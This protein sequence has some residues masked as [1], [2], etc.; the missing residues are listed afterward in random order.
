MTHNVDATQ[1]LIVEKSYDRVAT[2]LRDRVPGV[3]VVC[4]R[5][6]RNFTRDAKAV[7][8]A[9]V[10]P[11]AAWIGADV[12]SGG[13]LADY[14]EV[15]LGFES[16]QWV[17]SANAG[18]DA[19]LYQALARRGVRLTK[20]GAQSIPIAEY[21]LAYA[22]ERFQDLDVRRAAQ[23]EAAWKPHRFRELWHA[24]WLI[25]GYGHIGRG[26]ARRAKAFDSR[27]IAIRASG[28]SHEYADEVATLASL[29]ELLPRAN[30]VVLACPATDETRGLAN[31]SFFERLGPDT[32]FINVARGSL[33]DEAALLGGL[34]RERPSHAVLDVFQTEPLPASSP[35]WNHPRVTV[36]A[37]TSNAGSGT[38]IRG[39][40]LFLSNLER[41]VAGQALIDE[42][43]R[44]SLI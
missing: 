41:F 33:V 29:R 42:V 10:A 3:D 21:V 40:E 11:A 26:V 8:C 24:T 15:L 16:L 23:A 13:H 30:V 27:V 18:L 28:A 14:G 7:D 20:S 36:T 34:A 25:I 37:H 17:Q 4:W 1:V 38:R 32:L 39:D 9:E 43:D 2:G 5:P 35:L 12:F 31:A 22:L 19:G 44:A 6:E